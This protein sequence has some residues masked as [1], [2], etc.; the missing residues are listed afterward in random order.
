MAMIVVFIGAGGIL[1]DVSAVQ[2]VA[3]QSGFVVSYL[4]GALI[5]EGIS[6]R[7]DYRRQREA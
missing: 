1:L 6:L 7:R 4:V 3:A 5:C 2:I